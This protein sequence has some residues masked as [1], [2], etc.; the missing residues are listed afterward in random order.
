MHVQT[1]ALIPE[2]MSVLEQAVRQQSSHSKEKTSRLMSPFS[3]DETRLE[4]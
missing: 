4:R 3:K 1:H 2:R